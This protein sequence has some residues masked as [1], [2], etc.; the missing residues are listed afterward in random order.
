[1]LC[2]DDNL[3]AAIHSRWIDE[4]QP[5]N[6]E[7]FKFLRDMITICAR[8]TC[9]SNSSVAIT[10]AAFIRKKTLFNSK[11]D[12]CLSKKLVNCYIWNVAVF[13]AEM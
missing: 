1:M 12:R 5:D 3:K 6:V 10:R 13:G 11:F 9:Q 7:C 2:V 4:K 8:C